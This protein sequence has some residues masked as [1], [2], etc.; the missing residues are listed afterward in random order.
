MDGQTDLAPWRSPLGRALHRN[1]S[2]VYA[3]YA[4]LATVQTDGRP[5]NRTIV[6]RGFVDQAMP[7]AANDL[8]F[9][10][11]R[12][13]E[14]ITQ[15]AQNP[16]GELCW[17]FPKTRE[18][19]RL[20]G[21]LHIIDAAHL[22]PAAQQLRRTTWHNLS[23]NARNSFA[24]PAPK[25]PRAAQSAFE[26]TTLNSNAP[27]ANFCLLLLSPTTVDHL[28][29]KGEPQNRCLYSLESGHWKQRSVN[30]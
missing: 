29:L 6:F 21:Q 14:K 19:F 16:W 17:Y 20:A 23:D 7:Q 13:S 2:L 1:R 24:W 26:M 30:P 12:R 27:I 9:I 11:D 28:E 25:Q 22:D 10:T 4:Q 18:Q 5:A 3:R 8:K 15:L